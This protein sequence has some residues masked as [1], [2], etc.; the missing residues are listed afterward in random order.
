VGL[1]VHTLKEIPSG[2]TRRYYIYLLDSGWK[3]PV[4]EALYENLSL[5]ADRASRT[6]SAVI[7]GP[8][9]VHF[10]DEVLS[11]HHI[12]GEP[13]EKLLPALLITTRH[14]KTICESGDD[15]RKAPHDSMLLIPLKKACKNATEVVA[16]V[17]QIFNDIKDE[18]R[19][20]NFE[21]A[22]QLQRGLKDAVV[23]A[24]ILQPKIGGAGIDLLKFFSALKGK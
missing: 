24:L 8:R 12:N 3:E 17:N 13:A 11:W 9:S 23:D 20:R 15:R 7:H 2:A 19:L 6:N 21:V 18:K 5:M 1:Y 10:A 4:S 14:P 16:L 22:R